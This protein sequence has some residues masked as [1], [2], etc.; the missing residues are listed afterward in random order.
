MDGVATF[1]EVYRWSG[2]SKDPVPNVA[3]VLGSLKT[4]TIGYVYLLPDVGMSDLEALASAVPEHVHIV[5]YRELSA[6]QHAMRT[7]QVQGAKLG[8]PVTAAIVVSIVS[9]VIVVMAIAFRIR[10]QRLRKASSQD[11]SLATTSRDTATGGLRT[12]HSS[13]NGLRSGVAHH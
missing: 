11:V 9:A 4:G 6:M 8:A 3:G 7:Q 10:S 13:L 2:A 12:E 1:K 5:G